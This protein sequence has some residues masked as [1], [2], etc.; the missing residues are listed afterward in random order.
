MHVLFS[1]LAAY[2]H[3]YPLVPLAHAAREEGHHVDFATGSVMHSSM[4][5][6][7]FDPIDAGMSIIEAGSEAAREMFDAELGSQ[8]EPEQLRAVG[9]A[10]FGTYLPRRFVTDLDVVF[11]RLEPDLLIF[12]AANSG[13]RFAAARRGVP[14]VAH[15]LG[16]FVSEGFEEHRRRL[17]EFADE[18]GIAVADEG[19]NP[20]IDI[21]PAS[22]QD[23]GFRVREHRIPMRPA[24]MA[25]SA[26]LPESI[27]RR[28]D[29]S[30]VY[31][32]FGTGFGT[33]ELLGAV[34]EALAPMDLRLVVA[35]GPG[36][37]V[38]ALGRVP[39]NVAVEQWVPQAKLLPHIDLL[40]HHGGSGT[41]LGGLREGVPQLVLPRGADQF[42]NAEAVHGS[43]AGERLLPQQVGTVAIADAARRLLNAETV[44]GA[45]K[46][47]ADEI[48]S[49][50]SPREIARNLPRLAE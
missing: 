27:F 44:R 42:A 26:P 39:D 46:G 28:T 12:D 45:A 30:L 33:P 6:A 35:T 14:A 29:D 31:V 49:M 2:G 9:A 1:S 48:A 41:T 20:Y 3:T 50:P 15:G 37:D 38:G 11:E 25:E 17:A 16:P 4:R 43:G 19:A 40:V 13:A 10:A 7:G 32:T 18:L 36:V 8:L 21:Y 22:L 5:T 23:A 34:I 47:I 24:P